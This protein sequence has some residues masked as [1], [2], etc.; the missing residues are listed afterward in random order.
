MYMAGSQGPYQWLV[1]DDE[2]FDLLEAC[3]VIVLGK[4]VAIISIDS[5]A[6][7]LN[8]AQQATGRQSRDRIAYS[9]KVQT[10][11]SLPR[12]GWDEWYIS[13]EPFDL[14]TSHLGE[15][16]FEVPHGPGHISDFVN[17][18]FVFHRDEDDSLARL[19]WQRMERIRPESYLGDNE[20]LN[21]ATI[22]EILFAKVHDAV[23]GPR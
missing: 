19:F 11:D 22:N 4:H 14:G 15:N 20:F 12:E 17:F 3:P 8:G 23:K 18:G 6:L 21:F 1:T 2:Q 13:E 5:S 9:P 7:S 10:I 16:I